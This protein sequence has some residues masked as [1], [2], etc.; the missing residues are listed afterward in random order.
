MPPVLLLGVRY[1]V[2]KHC[3]DIVFAQLII[4]M[5][6]NGGPR[7][8]GPFSIYDVIIFSIGSIKIQFRISHKL[9]LSL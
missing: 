5:Q 6:S 4:Q 7:L 1:V 9:N 8:S 2:I 3:V